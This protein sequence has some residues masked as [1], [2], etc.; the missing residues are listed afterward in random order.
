MVTKVSVFEISGTTPAQRTLPRDL[1]PREVRI[2][3][4]ALTAAL[5]PAESAVRDTAVP[6]TD[7]ALRGDFVAALAKRCAGCRPLTHGRPHDSKVVE[8]DAAPVATD[9]FDERGRWQ[10]SAARLV[11]ASARG[12]DGGTRDPAAA[13]GRL[14]AYWLGPMREHTKSHGPML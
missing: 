5:V 9:P 2:G 13:S 7:D 1:A 11:E 8:V 3:P 12:G 4:V 6:V 10:S 14:A